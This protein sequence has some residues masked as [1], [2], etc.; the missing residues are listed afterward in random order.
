MTGRRSARVSARVSNGTATVIHGADGVMA[1]QEVKAPKV[2]KKTA[3]KRAASGAEESELKVSELSQTPKRRKKEP[4]TASELPPSTP[5]P[6]AIAALSHRSTNHRRK[7]GGGTRKAAPNITNAPLQTPDGTKVVKYP[8]DLFESAL[9]SPHK[10]AAAG[11]TTENLLEKACA[12]LVSVDPKLQAVIDKHHC[13][14]FSPD[15]LQEIVEPFAALSSGIMAQQVSGAAASSIKNK[16]NAL[17]TLPP[18]TGDGSKRFPTPAQVVEKDIATLRTAGLSQRKAEYIHGLAEKF[19]SGEL[20]ARTLVE[21]TDEEVMEKLIAVRGLGRWSVEMF[22]CFGLK[23]TDIFSTGDLGVQRGMAAYVGKDVKKIK[24]SKDKGKWKYMSEAD[25]LKH[26]EKFRP[27][28][29]LFMWYMWR[30]EDVNLE[31]MKA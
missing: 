23:R 25:M 20:S 29:S 9:P 8:S 21:A 16:F 7:A 18:D 13:K 15:G 22:A 26:S 24:A 2:T 19:V 11:T 31:A 28:R 30:I 6:S 10:V 4:I 12:H 5:T 14:M 17:F 3:V 27:Y 1:G